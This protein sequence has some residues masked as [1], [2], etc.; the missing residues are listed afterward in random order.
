MIYSKRKYEL[1]Y[2]KIPEENNF[3]EILQL[4]IHTYQECMER[5]ARLE[6]KAIGFLTFI[7]IILAVSV[8]IVLFTLN[9][10][11]YF[12]IKDVIMLFSLFAIFYFSIYTFIFT[13]RAYNNSRKTYMLDHEDFT[14]KWNEE[15]IEFMG[16]ISQSFLTC[17][18]LNEK[19]TEDVLFNVDMCRIFLLF[20]FTS[21]VVFIFTFFIKTIGG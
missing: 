7:S 13:L 4:L 21:F 8:A 14:Y 1:E 9:K 10:I 20:S 3:N 6:N 19:M 2:K 15:K 5:K 11:E 12:N 16:G 18:N 17:I